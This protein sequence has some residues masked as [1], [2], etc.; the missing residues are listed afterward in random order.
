M[1]S[2]EEEIVTLLEFE[3][4]NL[5][6]RECQRHREMLEKRRTMLFVTTPTMIGMNPIIR[7]SESFDS[8]GSGG[9][10]WSSSTPR[11]IE[12]AATT[13]AS[14]VTQTLGVENVCIECNLIPT[15]HLCLKCK[16]VRVCV[17]C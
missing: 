8:S 10:D 9:T 4:A 14:N 6:E 5:Q 1:E 17:C 13:V 11:N 3:L 12:H 2:N 16:V 7:T 15:N